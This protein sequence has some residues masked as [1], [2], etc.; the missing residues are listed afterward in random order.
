MLIVLNNFYNQNPKLI[1]KI[2]IHLLSLLSVADIIWLIF[3]SGAWSHKTQDSLHLYWDSLKV[4]HS[5]IYFLA[6]VELI[7]KLLLVYYLFVDYKDKYS[8]KELIKFNYSAE[9]Q[10]SFSNGNTGDGLLKNQ[11]EY[12]DEY[13]NPY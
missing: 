7:L 11:G 1:S 8:W 10:N 6:V 9:K 12:N 3:M 2:I 4:M 5:I 13:K